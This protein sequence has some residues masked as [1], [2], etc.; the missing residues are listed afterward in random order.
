MASVVIPTYKRPESLRRCLE[1][2]RLQTEQR[3]EIILVEEKGPLACLRNS[4]WKL[5]T[6]KIIAFTDDDV[7]FTSHWLTEVI[8]SFK[9]YRVQGTSGPAIVPDLLRRNRDIFRWKWAKSL[10]NFMFLGDKSLL[11]GYITKAGAW[12]TGACYEGSSYEGRVDFLE[13]CNMAWRREV[14]EAVDGFDE[15]YTGIG[16]W[17]EPDLAFRVRKL[18][19]NDCLWFNPRAKL[20]HEVS[21]QG[22]YQWRK[23]DSQNRLKN[24][25]RFSDK[26]VSPCWQNK[27]YKAFLKIYY[28]LKGSIKW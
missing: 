4:G 1:S 26:W 13:A 9:D 3:F 2:L 7:V 10:Y 12:T 15:G 18:F 22:A 16:D 25:Y 5:A 20:Y 28:L 23:E 8:S 11:P 24:Y 14:L 27:M 17:S 21:Q 19:G 6:T